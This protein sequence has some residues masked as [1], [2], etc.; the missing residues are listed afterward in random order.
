LR[1][2]RSKLRRNKIG[3]QIVTADFFDVTIISLL[4][5]LLLLL[6]L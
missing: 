3:E 4:L 6:L 5:L 2:S 1:A